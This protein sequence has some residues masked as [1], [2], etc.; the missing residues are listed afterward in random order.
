MA[1]DA[2]SGE[3]VM[4]RDGESTDSSLKLICGE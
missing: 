4:R 1:Q 2:S 3:V